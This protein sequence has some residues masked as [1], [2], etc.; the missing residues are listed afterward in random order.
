MPLK[1]PAVRS[2][3]R[4]IR[5][6]RVTK[7]VRAPRRLPRS[8]AVLQERSPASATVV[9]FDSATPLALA[10]QWDQSRQ[11]FE[12]LCWPLSC[13]ARSFADARYGIGLVVGRTEQKFYHQAVAAYAQ[14]HRPPRPP[15]LPPAPSCRWADAA[16]ERKRHPEA[17]NAASRGPIRLTT[18]R[19]CSAASRQLPARRSPV[20]VEMKQPLQ[21]TKLLETRHQGPS[22]QPVGRGGQATTFGGTDTLNRPRATGFRVLR[23]SAEVSGTQHCFGEPETVARRSDE[24]SP[25]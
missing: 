17:A 18:I 11:A 6:T 10:G 3:A 21:A 5:R 1:A 4:P 2:P 25:S 15:R 13:K 8:A 7:A 22:E 19:T 9:S 24:R 20:F 12:T 23:S 14:A 16:L